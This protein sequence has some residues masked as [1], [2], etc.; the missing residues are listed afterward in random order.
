MEGRNLSFR[1]QP[2]DRMSVEVGAKKTTG[3]LQ[4]NQ[5]PLQVPLQV[6]V[7]LQ[8]RSLK[9]LG[10]VGRWLTDL[11][12]LWWR[13]IC[14]PTRHEFA[15]GLGDTPQR[16][17]GH[18][19]Q[20]CPWEGTCLLYIRPHEQNEDLMHEVA[21]RCHRQKFKK[22]EKVKTKVKNYSLV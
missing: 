21:M 17:K 13:A 6:L 14:P 10:Q 20:D 19:F 12:P 1:Q 9:E 8:G 5:V 18:V 15:K 16:H 3:S 11:H 2:R 7:L 22:K 4:G